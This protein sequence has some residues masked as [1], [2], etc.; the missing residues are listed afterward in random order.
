MSPLRADRRTTKTRQALM[1]AFVE[2][3]LADGYDSLTV[4]AIV[5]R[6]NVGRSTFYAHFKGREGILKESLSFPSFPLARVATGPVEPRELLPLLAHFTGQRALARQ[7]A[8]GSPRKAWIRRLAEL[9]EPGLSALA[10]RGAAQP[11]LSFGLIALLV[12]E[13]QLGM[14]TRWLLSH[15]TAKPLAFAEALVSASQAAV[16]ALLRCDAGAFVREAGATGAPP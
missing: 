8:E 5:A 13:L 14:L 2:L 10:V 4:D 3:M 11:G 6:A 9:I 1:G 15:E 7:F 12:A 16:V